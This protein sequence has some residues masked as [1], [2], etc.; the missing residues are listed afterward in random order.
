M[1]SEKIFVIGSKFSGSYNAPFP[2]GKTEFT[3]CIHSVNSSDGNF[4]GRIYYFIYL[5]QILFCFKI[6]GKGQDK[7]GEFVIHGKEYEDGKVEFIKDY[8]DKSHTGILYE[9]MSDGYTVKGIYKFTY[10]TFLINMNIQEDFSMT[11][12]I[13][14]RG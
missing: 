12:A 8:I 10:K 5:Y 7:Q 6:S 11:V 14:V 13:P 2:F 9:G 4:E 1:A 3:F